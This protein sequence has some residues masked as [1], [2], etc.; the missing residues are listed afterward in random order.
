[1]LRFVTLTA[2]VLAAV[3]V[4]ARLLKTQ[5]RVATEEQTTSGAK[6]YGPE[7]Q[8]IGAE[9]FD[10]FYKLA[11]PR[12]PEGSYPIKFSERKGAQT[13]RFGD[14]VGLTGL[15]F[16]DQKPII[17]RCDKPADDEEPLLTPTELAEAEKRFLAAYDVMENEVNFFGLRDADQIMNLWK[18]TS[19]EW[20]RRDSIKA[21][22]S[23]QV[24]RQKFGH[25]VFKMKRK[26]FELA[27]WDSD[28]YGDCA[29]KAY[30]VGHGLAL[31]QAQRAKDW[32]DMEQKRQCLTMALGLEGMAAYYLTQLFSAD[33]MRL[34]RSQLIN[35]CG[36]YDAMQLTRPMVEEDAF[37][38]M[39]VKNHH[40]DHWHMFGRG[41]LADRRGEKSKVYAVEAIANSL[42]E[43][44]ASFELSVTGL[45]SRPAKVPTV[46]FIPY[47]NTAMTSNP[48]LLKYEKEK[49]RLMLRDAHDG[50]K[51]IP[52]IDPH[53]KKC[54]SAFDLEQ[55]VQNELEDEK[56]ETGFVPPTWEDQ[57]FAKTPTDD[58]EGSSDE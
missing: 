43:V 21:R 13:L 44:F 36:V 8:A 50:S 37:F 7:L 46:D 32:P 18:L 41:R 22:D 42:T 30:T 54:R 9:G 52:L 4:N 15:M 24:A 29:L 48:P 31:K 26:L 11:K 53:T 33:T 28:S 16:R 2:V 3:A 25:L 5:S 1:M 55:R 12:M 27:H 40:H 14:I 23:G 6:F 51:Y 19:A 34:P 56:S 39:P 58:E 17:D 49:N 20:K 38:G 10:H 45:A 57:K 35:E 47:L